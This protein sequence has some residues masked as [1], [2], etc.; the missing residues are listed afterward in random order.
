MWV[1]TNV[2]YQHELKLA[3][4]AHRRQTEQALLQIDEKVVAGT[5]TDRVEGQRRRVGHLLILTL[6]QSGGSSRLSINMARVTK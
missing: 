2:T 4:V 6:N 3:Q 1:V 5:Y